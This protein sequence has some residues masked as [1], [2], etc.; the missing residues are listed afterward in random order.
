LKST[1]SS[2]HEIDFVSSGKEAFGATF[3]RNTFK[4]LHPARRQ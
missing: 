4:V 1:P 3:P 2:H